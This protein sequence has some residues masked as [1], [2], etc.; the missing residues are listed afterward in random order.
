MEVQPAL[1][2]QRASLY[3]PNALSGL[4]RNQEIRKAICPDLLQQHSPSCPAPQF[5]AEH[6]AFRAPVPLLRMILL[7]NGLDSRLFKVGPRPLWP[8]ASERS[9]TA[10]PA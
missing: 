4:Q 6:S 3:G 10:M 9:S 5:L 2:V 1:W 7:L 8:P